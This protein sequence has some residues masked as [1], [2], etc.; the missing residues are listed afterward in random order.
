MCSFAIVV[1]NTSDQ[2]SGKIT[3]EDIA[4]L[5]NGAV[6]T[7]LSD[8][9]K[10][11]TCIKG[12][13][14]ITCEL[15]SV[16]AKSKS[17]PLPASFRPV[18]GSRQIENCATI[19]GTTNKACASI[20]LQPKFQI[21]P[22]VEVTPQ[23]KIP[24]E[25][26]PA[27]PVLNIPMQQFAAPNLRVDKGVLNAA[28]CSIDGVCGFAIT[29]TNT[30]PGVFKGKISLIDMVLGGLSEKVAAASGTSGWTCTPRYD[31]GNGIS[32][33]QCIS[34][35]ITLPVN[36]VHPLS[37]DVVP[38]SKWEKN[39]K[40]R[41]CAYV[42]YPL[43]NDPGT[44]QDDDK[45]CANVY[46]DPFAV[47]MAKTGD[48]SCQPGGECHFDL[49]L[50]NPGPIDHNA[51]V[52]LTDGLSGIGPAD[53][54]SIAPP[55]PCATQPTQ[56]PFTCTS[57]G[58]HP[59]KIGA[60]EHFSVTVRLPSEPKT[61]A[62]TNCASVAGAGSDGKPRAGGPA[63][64][65]TVQIGSGPALP[66]SS[67]SPSGE[68]KLVVEKTATATSCTDAGGGCTFDIVVRNTGT[69]PFP[70]PIEIQE[71]VKADGALAASS[72]MRADA[73]APWACSKAAPA[74]FACRHPGPLDPG[75][76]AR[77]Q[78]N[79]GLRAD[80]GAKEI[81]NCAALKGSAEQACAKIPLGAPAETPPPPVTCHGGM[82]PTKVGRCTCPP[83]TIWQR[84][85]CVADTSGGGTSTSKDVPDKSKAEQ[86]PKPKGG[87]SDT[88]RDTDR[89]KVEEIPKPKGG[90]SDTSRDT[91]SGKV[92]QVPKPK[93]C[94]PDRPVGTYPNC[95][96]RNTIFSNGTCAK[97]GGG[98]TP[99]R[100]P[101]AGKPLTK[102][103]GPLTEPGTKVGPILRKVCPP[104]RPV[105]TYPNCC[106]KGTI[107]TK[108]GCAGG[109]FNT[110][111][112]PPARDSTKGKVEQ[113]PKPNAC[114]P[115]RPIGKPPLC[116]P[117]GTTPGKAGCFK[118]KPSDQAPDVNKNDILTKPGGGVGDFL[119]QK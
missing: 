23:S 34:D 82:V 109:G 2:P 10:P 58:N 51:P 100:E 1:T 74:K 91:D 89:G 27:P 31:L 88:S 114:P 57:P 94:P 78:V 65:H 21:P 52:T 71:T 81:E 49:K 3:V 90:G 96:P 9:P 45:G 35:E 76:K 5:D 85:E 40:L 28:T 116:C 108:D 79:F 19:Q 43:G 6:P 98:A 29:V 93:V 83:G 17:P 11:W 84:R 50:F 110:S 44:K 104:D 16:A 36:G 33:A 47:K 69:G 59:L 63:T 105:G 24:V 55:L 107:Y 101:P 92:E 112:E 13:G 8:D 4:R 67:K 70:G 41:N 61:G 25:E 117:V 95:C 14:T 60:E 119:K 30:G 102:D 80:T 103:T 73:N 46:L 111:R 113:L 62:F 97:I 86:A 99:S 77:L 26:P 115:D 53:I 15:P 56:L 12:P 72:N 38:G 48:Q 7:A 54:V 64:C 39:D 32:G 75:K 22:D 87:G 118:P 18:V 66:D 68:P 37:I 42:V 106:P 20:P